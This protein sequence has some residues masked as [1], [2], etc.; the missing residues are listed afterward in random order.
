M[1]MLDGNLHSCYEQ[2]FLSHLWLLPSLHFFLRHTHTCTVFIRKSSNCPARWQLGIFWAV[3]SVLVGRSSSTNSGQGTPACALSLGL[4]RSCEGHTVILQLSMWPAWFLP[5]IIFNLGL[6]GRVG[7]VDWGLGVGKQEGPLSFWLELSC[8]RLTW[9]N[10]E[11]T[12]SYP[13]IHKAVL[14]SVCDF[15]VCLGTGTDR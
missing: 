15:W 9:E 7:L 3:A 13:A 2:I 6:R 11:T 10:W 14:A 1:G 12:R 4:A 8:I 5:I